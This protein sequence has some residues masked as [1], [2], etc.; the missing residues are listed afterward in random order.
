MTEQQ[1][2]QVMVT[3]LEETPVDATHWSTRSLAARTGMS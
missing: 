2:E 1:V 3:T